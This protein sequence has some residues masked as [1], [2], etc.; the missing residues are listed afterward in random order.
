MQSEDQ[1]KEIARL[2]D[3]TEEVVKAVLAA[4]YQ[5]RYVPI[6]P[7]TKSVSAGTSDIT[8]HFERREREAAAKGAR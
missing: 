8:F 3:T 6:E 7:P 5:V 1:I 4:Y 2:A